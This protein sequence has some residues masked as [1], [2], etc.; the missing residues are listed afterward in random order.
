MFQDQN[1]KIR[2]AIG[3]VMSRICQYHSD[4]VSNPN[5]ISVIIPVFLHALNDKPKIS[6]QICFAIEN[7]AVSLAPAHE[8]QA[9]NALTPFFDDLFKALGANAMRQYNEKQVD[10]ALA[11]FTALSALV[12]HSCTNSN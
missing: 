9:T 4:V 1:S 8:D 6:N 5:S 2:E 7:L 11:S 3:W 10:L 12:E